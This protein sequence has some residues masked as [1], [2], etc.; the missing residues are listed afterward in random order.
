[1]TVTGPREELTDDAPVGA[2]IASVTRRRTPVRIPAERY[3]SPV[4]A[5]LEHAKVWPKVWQ[6]ACSLDHVA[7]PGDFFEYTVGKYSVM[8]VRG[9]DGVLRA[10]LYD[11][12]TARKAKARSTGNASRGYSSLPHIGFNNLYL[13]PGEAPPEALIRDVRVGFYVT[14][15]LGHGA[16]IVTGE[17]SRGANGL[18]IENGELAGPVQEVTVAGNL[19]SMLDGID[20]I[21]ND[22]TF[23][24]AVGAPTVRFGELTVSGE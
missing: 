4:W 13:Q 17:Y 9:S 12:F 20:G 19:L 5:D 7:N 16:N 21:A 15:M 6:L 18:W 2:T 11:S 1:M 3:T 10:F 22:L 23:R 14:A 24:G 8:I